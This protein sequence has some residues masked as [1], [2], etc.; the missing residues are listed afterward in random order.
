MVDVVK[1]QLMVPCR[2]DSL[3]IYIGVF[4]MIRTNMAFQEPHTLCLFA[5]KIALKSYVEAPHSHCVNFFLARM[6]GRWKKIITRVLGKI[7]Q[8]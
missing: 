3:K 2:F 7:Y 1:L 8:L 5:F 4:V 6:F